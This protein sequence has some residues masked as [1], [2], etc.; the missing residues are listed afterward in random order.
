[1]RKSGTRYQAEEDMHR[2]FV[3]SVS[4]V[5]LGRFSF[6]SLSPVLW[7]ANTD[8]R[9]SFDFAFTIGVML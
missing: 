7:Q 6:D 8:Q 2:S 9:E 4:A 1:M 3:S 5:L